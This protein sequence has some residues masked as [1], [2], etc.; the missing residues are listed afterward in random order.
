MP[1][2]DKSYIKTTP[3]RG[4]RWGGYVNS[5]SKSAE[6]IRFC[7]VGVIATALDGILPEP[8]RKLSAHDILDF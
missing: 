8:H 4:R 1:I 7:I 5:D 3:P 6:F 2:S